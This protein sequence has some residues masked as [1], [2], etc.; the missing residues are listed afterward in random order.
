L[1]FIY[2]FVTALF[3]AGPIFFFE[4]PNHTHTAV[5]TQHSHNTHPTQHAN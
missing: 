3:E 2:P 1:I 5:E 4:S